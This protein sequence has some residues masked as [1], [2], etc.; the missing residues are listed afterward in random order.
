MKKLIAVVIA[1]AA[2]FGHDIL[3]AAD[4]VWDQSGLD[5]VVGLAALFFGLPALWWWMLPRYTAVCSHDG[6]NWLDVAGVWSAARG[7]AGNDLE[8]FTKQWLGQVLTGKFVTQKEARLPVNPVAR[9]H[10]V[11]LFGAER[12]VYYVVGVRVHD[13]AI[14]S[15]FPE[16][17]NHAPVRFEEVDEY[18]PL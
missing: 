3:V 15:K 8:Q 6:S 9:R 10:H 12:G 2:A 18:L 7:V 13:E 17:V 1:I 16:R 5:S 14:L 4:G 11:K